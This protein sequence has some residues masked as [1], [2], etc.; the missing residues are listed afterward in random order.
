MMAVPF[1]NHP[2]NNA[3]RILIMV[4]SVAF[5]VIPVGHVVCSSFVRHLA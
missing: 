4:S 2:D 1:F 5:S 3:L